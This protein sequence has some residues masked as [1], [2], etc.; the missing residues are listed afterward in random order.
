[1]QVR[2][3]F[4]CS[5]DRVHAWLGRRENSSLLKLTDEIL[6]AISSVLHVEITNRYQSLFGLQ[7]CKSNTMLGDLA[8]TLR[9]IT[10]GMFHQDRENIL[11]RSILNFEPIFLSKLPRHDEVLF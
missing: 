7:C 10:L 11:V 4:Q 1:M 6:V 5:G 9:C 3:R 8:P 2:A